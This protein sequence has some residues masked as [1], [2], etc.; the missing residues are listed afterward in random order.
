MDYSGLWYMDSMDLWNS[1]SM[2]IE[3]GSADFLRFPSKKDSATHDWGDSNGIDVDLSRIFLK[4]RKGV[5]QCAILAT[6]ESEFWDK[7]EAFFYRLIQPGLRRLE[8]N[9]HGNRSYFIFYEDNPLYRQVTKL[10]GTMSSG[11]IAHRFNLALVEP[12]PVLN[13]SNVFI[14]TDDGKFIIS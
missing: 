13:P 8:F 3:E 4:E 1:F 5:L 14:V 2:I 6:S 7:H 12:E 11:L 9:S 10:K